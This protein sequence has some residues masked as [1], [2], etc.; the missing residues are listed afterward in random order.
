MKRSQLNSDSSLYLKDI[1]EDFCESIKHEPV[2][3]DAIERIL[4]GYYKVSKQIA[5][6]KLVPLI[7][8]EEKWVLTR[9][10]MDISYRGRREHDA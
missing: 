5:K 4:T 9:K 8:Q 6:E 7:L 2:L 1:A 3:L 10:A